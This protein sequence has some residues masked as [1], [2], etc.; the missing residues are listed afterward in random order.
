[1]IAACPLSLVLIAALRPNPC[2][3]MLADKKALEALLESGLPKGTTVSEPHDC[4]VALKDDSGQTLLVLQMRGLHAWDGWSAELD[5]RTY[6][7]T[8]L[9]LGDSAFFYQSRSDVQMPAT[10]PGERVGRDEVVPEQQAGQ[11]CVA[12][13]S[14]G[15]NALQLRVK[16]PPERAHQLLDQIVAPQ[17]QRLREASF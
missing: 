2:S 9:P 7:S 1:M 13:I 5:A 17:L 12:L 6:R 8:P 14:A 15:P 11:Q 10:L 16:G 4:A 3:R